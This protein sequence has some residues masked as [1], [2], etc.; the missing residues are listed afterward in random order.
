MWVGGCLQHAVE[1]RCGCAGAYNT[2]WS[3]GVGARVLTT[4]SVG[5]G[6]RVLTTE[7][8]CVFTAQSVGAGGR[9]LLSSV[10]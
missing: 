7:C 5:V 6:R 9:V 8:R 3:V 10:A 2:Q 4:R 1:C